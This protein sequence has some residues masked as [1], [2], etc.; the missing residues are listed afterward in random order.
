MFC[1][2]YSIFTLIVTAILDIKTVHSE[3][4]SKYADKLFAF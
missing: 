2:M 3:I 4:E 1:G